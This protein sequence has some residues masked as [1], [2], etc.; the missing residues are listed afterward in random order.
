MHRESCGGSP[1]LL[2]RTS[3]LAPTFARTHCRSKKFAFPWPQSRSR[4]RRRRCRAAQR[5][6]PVDRHPPPPPEV[7]VCFS[8]GSARRAIL[9][10]SLRETAT[11]SPLG[12]AAVEID[13]NFA[14]RS[15]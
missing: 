9:L 4:I 6:L 11:R 13:E 8:D 7:L 3:S 12:I 15:L 14:G 10:Q 1:W 2:R 5:V